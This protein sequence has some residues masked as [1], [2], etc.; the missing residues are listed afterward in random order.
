MQRIWLVGIIVAL[1]AT[2]IVIG[3]KMKQTGSEVKALKIK[4]PQ[5]AAKLEQATFATGCFWGAEA[6]FRKLLAKGVVSTRVGYTGGNVPN[7]S[8]EQVC[9]HTTGHFEAVEVTFDPSKISYQELL[10]VFWS[11][12]NPLR[13]DGQGPDVGPQYRA[14]I[15]YHTPEQKRLAEESKSALEAARYGGR[16]IATLIQ[17]AKEFYPAEEYHQQYYEKKGVAGVCPIY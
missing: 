14:A 9:S 4:Q 2:V 12:H 3:G 1:A 5:D 7:P 17:P 8:Y 6:A 16:G 10:E 11:Q 13:D 15:F